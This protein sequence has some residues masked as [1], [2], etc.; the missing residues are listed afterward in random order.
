MRAYI[1]LRGAYELGRTARRSGKSIN[2]SDCWTGDYKLQTDLESEWLAGW[3]EED[4]HHKF[5][6]RIDAEID[7]RE[8][9]RR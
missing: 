1:S 5:H 6:E 7:C 2:D 4:R 9:N 8:R 3:M